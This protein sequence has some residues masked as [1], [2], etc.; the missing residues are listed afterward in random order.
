MGRK[1]KKFNDKDVQGCW[2]TTAPNT[3]SLS[4]EQPGSSCTH[5]LLLLVVS[6]QTASHVIPEKWGGGVVVR[7]CLLMVVISCLGAWRGSPVASL[8]WAWTS[9]GDT[10][11]PS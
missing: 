7:V 5:A 1:H 4:E 2:L 8:C 11:S 9:A 10:M 6:A 3:Q